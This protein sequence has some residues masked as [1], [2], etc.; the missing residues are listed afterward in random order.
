VIV[1]GT[2]LKVS[3]FNMLL[4]NVSCPIVVINRENPVSPNEKYV[5]F[6]EGDIET[7]IKEIAKN[8]GWEKILK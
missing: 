5:L 1:M 7:N 4:E 8:I 3:P 6:F 2:S